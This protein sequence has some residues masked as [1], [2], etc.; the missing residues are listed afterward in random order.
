M[1]SS[2]KSA[3]SITPQKHLLS[4][5]KY[6]ILFNAVLLAAIS[7]MFFFL[8]YQLAFTDWYQEEAAREDE[9][10]LSKLETYIFMTGMML[11]FIIQWYVFVSSFK[12]KKIVFESPIRDK[13]TIIEETAEKHGLIYTHEKELKK[14]G[15]QEG[16]LMLQVYEA[17]ANLFSGGRCFYVY[18]D[19]NAFHICAHN[20][21]FKSYSYG[22]GARRQ[23]RKI[24]REIESQLN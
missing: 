22:F 17:Q 13:L 18:S 8:F 9:D 15:L 19:K 2:K 23:L 7:G 4:T 6:T 1:S 3:K 14:R 24:A 16:G 5:S 10:S 12:L 20:G 11:L 21:H